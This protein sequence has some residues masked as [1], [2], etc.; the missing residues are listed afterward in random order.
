MLKLRQI[1]VMSRASLDPVAGTPEPY[2]ASA[3]LQLAF[4][5]RAL[6]SWGQKATA[7]P[8]SK[9]DR[10][11]TRI[12]SEV[13]LSSDLPIPAN[14]PPQRT[15]RSNTMIS[16]LFHT[17]RNAWV[18]PFVLVAYWLPVI[19]I[20]QKLGMPQSHQRCNRQARPD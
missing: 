16:R 9:D 10:L 13:T 12:M 15:S 6:L 8:H 5:T 4:A 11:L 2:M 19:P 17:H 20:N 18:I 7:T 14:C 3:V 1:W